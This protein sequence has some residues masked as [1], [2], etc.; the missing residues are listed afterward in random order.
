M[1][2]FNPGSWDEAYQDHTEETLLL[3]TS[4]DGKTT[5]ACGQERHCSQTLCDLYFLFVKDLRL[6]MT[7]YLCKLLQE[8]PL[9]IR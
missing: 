1:M 5:S 7:V 2:A 3:T 6:S 8:R 9:A 4:G